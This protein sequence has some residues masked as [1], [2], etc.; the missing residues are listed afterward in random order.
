MTVKRSIMS[1]PVQ[2]HVIGASGRTGVALCRS[3]LADG[4]AV[5]AGR[6]Q[7]RQ[8][9]GDRHRA[10]RRASPTLR[11]PGAFV[12]PGRMPTRIVCCAHARHARAVIDAAPT[13]ARFVFLG[14]T[15]KFTSWPDAHGDGVLAGES[16]FLA[17][18]RSGVMLH[19]TMIYGA[20]GR[21]QRP[22]SRRPAA[23]AADRAA[24]RRRQG[25][26]AADP[27]GRRH[28]RD[29]RRTG[30]PLGRA[31]VAGDRRAR[32]PCPTPISCA[33]SPPPRD[34]GRRASSPCRQGC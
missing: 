10:S 32:P 34:C 16:A 7:R 3:L 22:A 4:G 33:P 13:A 17:S 14:S 6:A 21:G 9:G 29:P 15:R 25:A 12:P 1:S 24:A 20:R 18:G 31:A 2:V 28:P 26:G 11:M 8:M 27:P 23:T 30:A 19:P 5:G